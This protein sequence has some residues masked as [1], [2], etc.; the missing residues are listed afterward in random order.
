M[1][2]REQSTDSAAATETD[3]RITLGVM[4]IDQRS[5]EGFEDLL[6]V[7]DGKKLHVLPPRMNTVECAHSTRD[8][9]PLPEQQRAAYTSQE[10]VLVS[11]QST[12]EIALVL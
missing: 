3:K 10:N 5:Q 2:R 8:V 6:G 11:D 4:T 1:F 9:K 12:R 7:Q